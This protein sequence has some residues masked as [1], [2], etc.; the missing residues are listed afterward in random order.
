MGGV[1]LIDWFLCLLLLLGYDC[2]FRQ[3]M[4]LPEGHQVMRDANVE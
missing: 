4:V 2:I 1:L 3:D